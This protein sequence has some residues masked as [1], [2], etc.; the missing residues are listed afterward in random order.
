MRPNLQGVTL[1]NPHIFLLIQFSERLESIERNRH[2]LQYLRTIAMD[3]DEEE[4]LQDAEARLDAI[5]QDLE[6]TMMRLASLN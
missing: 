5:Q 2:R 3:L 1:P 6:V 4:M